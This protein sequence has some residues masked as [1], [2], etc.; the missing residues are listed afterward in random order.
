MGYD[1]EGDLFFF[2]TDAFAADLTALT[3]VEALSAEALQKAA[4]TVLDVDAYY[5]RD[6]CY[7]QRLIWAIDDPHALAALWAGLDG[8]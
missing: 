4:T 2:R 1:R 6:Q 5:L 8:A 3:D 7:G